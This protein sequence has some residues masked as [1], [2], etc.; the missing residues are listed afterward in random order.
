MRSLKVSEYISVGGMD[1]KVRSVVLLS[2]LLS[3][4]T[5]EE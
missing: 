5:Q 4:I 2:T 3:L 1:I